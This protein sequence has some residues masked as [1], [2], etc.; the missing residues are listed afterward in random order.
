MAFH[1]SPKIINSG[2]VLYMD[3]INT[4]CYTG[5]GSS[6]NNLISGVTGSL[7]GT[8]SSYNTINKSFDTNSTSIFDNS[9]IVTETITFNDAST[10]TLDFW[11]KIRNGASTTT[12]SLCG[13]GNTTQPWV[14]VYV[15]TT[16]NWFIRFRESITATYFDFTPSTT[17]ITKWSNIVLVFNSN[18]V[19]NLYLNGV[20]IGTTTP[21]NTSLTIRRLAAGYASG[22]NY[23]PLQGSI[24]ATKIY[25]RNLSAIEVLQNYNALKTRFNS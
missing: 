9:G 22:G 23:Y 2:L 16:T 3:P 6:W 25:N 1:Y 4:K 13:P 10:Y 19:I 14:L 12:N 17:D 18:R 15:T 11:I 24:S 21:N 20:F 7:Y 8:Y 5:T